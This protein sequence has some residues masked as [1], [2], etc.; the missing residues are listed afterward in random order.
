MPT[1]DGGSSRY[2]IKYK[3]KSMFPKSHTRDNS[4]EFREQAATERNSRNRFNR[5]NNQTVD[6]SEENQHEAR[7]MNPKHQR[8][9]A[10]HAL[11]AA[12]D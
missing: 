1:R 2:A 12:P 9:V 8:Y 3:P 5:S 6:L 4:A 7:L 10:S 11:T